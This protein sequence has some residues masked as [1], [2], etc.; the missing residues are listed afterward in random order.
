M[1]T[2]PPGFEFVP[3][4]GGP[5]LQL[6][7]EVIASACPANDGPGAPWR[8]C[9]HPRRPPRYE[10]LPD[11][12]ACRRYMEAWARR[13]EGQIREHLAAPSS[14]FQH[15]IPAGGVAHT[16]HIRPRARR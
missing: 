11:E 6:D 3:Y 14:P 13:W 15:L 9:I 4:L 12:A 2:L 1:E 10:F 7:G 8:L 16:T 5:A